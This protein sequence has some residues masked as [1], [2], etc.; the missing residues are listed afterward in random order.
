MLLLKSWFWPLFVLLLGV[1]SGDVRAQERAFYVVAH[2]WHASLVLSRAEVPDAVWPEQQDFPE[3][4]YLEVGWGDARFYQAPEPGLGT[5]LRAG[6]WPTPSVLHVVGF[7]RP[8]EQYFSHSEVVRIVVSEEALEGV[9]T[10]IHGAYAQDEAGNPVVLGSGL[11]GES[12]FYQAN[13]RYHAFNNCNVWVARAL[14]RAGCSI[15]GQPL[16][17]KKLMAQVR[18]C[19]EVIQGP[20]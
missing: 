3:A 17:V 16:T 5:T 20:E 8:V 14:K 2:D 11:Y 1:L 15:G 13:E 18:A 4:A 12:R 6:L 7:R 19:G 9:A 10:Y